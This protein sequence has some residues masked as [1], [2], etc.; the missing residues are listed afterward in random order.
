MANTMKNSCASAQKL[1]SI[2]LEVLLRAYYSAEENNLASFSSTAGKSAIHRF[3]AEDVLVLDPDTDS[4][5]KHYELTELG[6]AWVQM[7]L[8]TP[9]P[10]YVRILVDPRTELPITNDHKEP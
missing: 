2:E 8:A 5:V 9:R 10:K 1:R 7:I 4:S 3:L 6:K